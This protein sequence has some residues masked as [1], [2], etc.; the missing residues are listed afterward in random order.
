MQALTPGA[1]IPLI[2][3]MYSIIAAMDLAVVPA[4]RSRNNELM[5][6]LAGMCSARLLHKTQ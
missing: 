4:D 5:A 6:D 1:S 2:A 3:T